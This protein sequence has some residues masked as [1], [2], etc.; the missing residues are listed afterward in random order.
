MTNDA[1]NHK[2]VRNF[3]Y[4][5]IRPMD[6]PTHDP[7]NDVRADVSTKPAGGTLVELQLRE[8][9]FATRTDPAV[10][11]ASH[12][13]RAVVDAARAVRLTHVVKWWT[14]FSDWRW[15][16]SVARHRR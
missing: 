15:L 8:P 6:N 3:A 4:G 16:D 11:I 14:L 12:S 10:S 1:A 5:E 7:E 13:P 2:R 9:S